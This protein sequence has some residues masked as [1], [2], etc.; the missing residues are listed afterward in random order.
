MVEPISQRLLDL[1]HWALAWRACLSTRLSH[2]QVESVTRTVA[3]GPRSEGNPRNLSAVVELD[4]IP[5]HGVC[6]AVGE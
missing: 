5:R 4:R 1:I 2:G 3:E 6:Y